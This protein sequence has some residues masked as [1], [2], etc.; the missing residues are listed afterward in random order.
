MLGICL[1]TTEIATGSRGPHVKAR[2]GAVATQALTNPYLGKLGIRLLELGYTPEK[3]LEEL[4]QNDAHLGY[5]QLGVV[6][7]HGNSAVYTGSQ[8]SEWAGHIAEKN[9]IAMGNYLASGDVVKAMADSFKI[10]TGEA[11]EE[12][13]MRSIEA[14]RDAGGQVNGR[15]NSAAMIVC[16]WDTLPRIDLRADWHDNDAIAELRR[17]LEKYKP[18]VPYYAERPMNPTIGRFTDWLEERGIKWD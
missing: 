12:R 11:L 16:D 18:L 3:V 9:F 17:F 2:V 5:R 15:Q 6:D 14:G 4:K 10:S 8:N 1:A 13:L 7:R